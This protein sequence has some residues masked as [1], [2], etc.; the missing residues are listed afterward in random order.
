MAS[1]GR[2][3]A[4]Q[5]CSRGASL[6]VTGWDPPFEPSFVTNTGVFGFAPQGDG[7]NTYGTGVWGDSP[8]TGVYGTGGYGVEGYGYVGV[9][10]YATGGTGSVGVYAWT[11][12]NAARALQVDGK[13]HLSRSGRKSIG[14]GKSSV[15]VTLSGVTTSSMVF[16]VL[17]TSETGRWVRAVVAAS[18]KFTIYL[19]TSLKSSAVVSWFVL[20]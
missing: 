3:R 11:N 18:G 20:D 12:S 9:A 1:K 17:A 6:E 13:V 14:S 7:V 10:G 15:A 8:D 2:P 4:A 16:A 19:N 5:G